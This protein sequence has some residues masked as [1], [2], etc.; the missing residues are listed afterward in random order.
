MDGY[1][2]LRR[3]KEDKET[4]EGRHKE[5]TQEKDILWMC[6]GLIFM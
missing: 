5:N 3:I 4:R 2:V 6:E 1:E